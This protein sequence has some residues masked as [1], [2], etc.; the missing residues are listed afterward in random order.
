MSSNV[1]YKTLLNEAIQQL[2]RPTV[3]FQSYRAGGTLN[4]PIYAADVTFCG[5]EFFSR[6]VSK[7]GYG[8]QREA[9]QAAAQAAIQAFERN[10]GLTSR[11]LETL[12]ALQHTPTTPT[13][14][15]STPHHPTPPSTPPPDWD[16]PTQT[17][18]RH[19]K[20][21]LGYSF[22]DPTLLSDALGLKPPTGTPSKPTQQIVDDF[23]HLAWLG[24]NILTTIDTLVTFKRSPQFNPAS[25]GSASLYHRLTIHHAKSLDERI[26]LIS[27]N[28]HLTS[29]RS[30]LAVQSGSGVV[31]EFR[32]EEYPDTRVWGSM[33]LKAVVGAIYLDAESKGE[34]DAV[35]IV[36]GI[37]GKLLGELSSLM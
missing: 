16:T 33:A 5:L 24:Y 27:S 26:G 35:A 13:T 3:S 23:H 11:A 14:T 7:A 31:V 12:K 28:I 10:G 37:W 6:D 2:A 29:L 18:F 22:Q 30:S 19:I 8:S 36:R 15:S 32:K 1:N 17:A 20:D 4:R 34:G 25:S 21:R 9:E